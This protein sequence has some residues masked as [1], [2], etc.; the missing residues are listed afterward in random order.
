LL[1]IP[2]NPYSGAF[3]AVFICA[4]ANKIDVI[5]QADN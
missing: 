5:L 4:K 1:S 3:G 2:I